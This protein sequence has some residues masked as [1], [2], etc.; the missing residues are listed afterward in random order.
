MADKDMTVPAHVHIGGVGGG[1]YYAKADK[2]E[3]VQYA[4]EQGARASTQMSA[5]A[6]ECNRATLFGGG[7]LS[8]IHISEPTRR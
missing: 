2:P 4:F 8:L 6:C 3:G 1:Q 7:G 5:V